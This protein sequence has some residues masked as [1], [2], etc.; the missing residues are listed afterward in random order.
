MNDDRSNYDEAFR[1]V[2]AGD[3]VGGGEL[4]YEAIFPAL[5]A[6]TSP[7]TAFARE[8][9]E[10]AW[11]QRGTSLAMHL[12]SAVASSARALGW[13]TLALVIARV[14][15]GFAFV[16]PKLAEVEDVEALVLAEVRTRGVEAARGLYVR[17]VLTEG[18]R[19][20]DAAD[21]V[22]AAWKAFDGTR[23][24]SASVDLALANAFAVLAEVT[25]TV[26]VASHLVAAT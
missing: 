21:A 12:R 13:L 11:S 5:L 2:R 17:R 24:T 14:G 26:A 8:A 20:L 6:V 22:V 19:L 10:P 1:R 16:E 23:S 4:V 9:T 7:L 25:P 15:R 3:L 18:T